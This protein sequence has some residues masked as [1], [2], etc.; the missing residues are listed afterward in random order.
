MARNTNLRELARRQ[1]WLIVII[2]VGICVQILGLVPWGS[3]ANYAH[4]VLTVILVLL[5]LV[6]IIVVV[7]ALNAEGTNPITTTLCA[8]LMLAP[9]I[10]LFLLFMINLS[11]SR[12]LRRSGL[13]VGFLGISEERI[14]K[15]LNPSLCSTCAYDLTGNISGICPECGRPAPR[16][17]CTTCEK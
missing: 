2:A 1:R 14:E 17:F 7:L 13:K 3:Y 12:T 4:V 16:F 5:W 11:F 6:S 10:N 8:F 15:A 9:C